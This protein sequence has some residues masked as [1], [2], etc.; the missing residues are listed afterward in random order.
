MAFLKDEIAAEPRT[1]NAMGAVFLTKEGP[2][3]FLNREAFSGND[4]FS[5]AYNHLIGA[6]KVVLSQ[7]GA[8]TRPDRQE[9]LIR[10][11]G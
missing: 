8:E 11:N 7:A 5:R 9:I 10:T 3:I 4:D 1:E 2:L 6:A